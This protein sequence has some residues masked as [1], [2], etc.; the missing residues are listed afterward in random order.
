MGQGEGGVMD[1][2]RDENRSENQSAAPSPD[3]LVERVESARARLDTLVSEL[4]QRR[5]VVTN[6]K[7]QMRQHPLAVIGGALAVLG[8]AGAITAFAVARARHNRELGV[9]ARRLAAAFGRIAR[10][11]DKVARSEPNIGKKVLSAAATTLASLAV[12]QLGKRLLTAVD[13]RSARPA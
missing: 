3:E 13:A 5:H 11:P 2:S 7:H 10:R 8:L 1:K 12:Q 9:R 4:D 6:L